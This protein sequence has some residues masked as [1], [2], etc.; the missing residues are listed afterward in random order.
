M[1]IRKNLELFKYDLV[2]PEKCCNM[3][4]K[5]PKSASI[6]PRRASE[7]SIKRYGTTLSKA[8]VVTLLHNAVVLGLPGAIPGRHNGADGPGHFLPHQSGD[9]LDVGKRLGLSWIAHSELDRIFI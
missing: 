8:P 9:L 2:E 7:R 3:S 1:K 5:L 4:L 6:Q